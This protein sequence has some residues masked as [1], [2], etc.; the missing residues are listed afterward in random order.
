ME[1]FPMQLNSKIVPCLWFNGQAEPA[2]KFYTSIFKDGKITHTSRYGEEGQ[3]IHGQKPGTVLTVAFEIAGQ[4]FTALNGGPIFKLSEAVSFQVMCDSQEEVD[5]FW[6]KLTPGGDPNS[7]Q[8]G[9][10][11]DQFGLSWQIVPREMVELLQSGDGVKTGRMMG[12]LMQM[13]KLDLAG[14]KKA[15]AG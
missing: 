4:S 12:A 1:R 5:Y 10:L 8:C 9:W 15:Y 14:L 7:Q 3:E 13:K 11:K 2:A 6:S